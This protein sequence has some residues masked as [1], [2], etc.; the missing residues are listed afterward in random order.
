MQTGQQE[1]DIESIHNFFNFLNFFNETNMILS[2]LLR[3]D[4]TN[5]L[6]MAKAGLISCT[7]LVN[8]FN[9]DIR[10]R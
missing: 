10:P 5:S 6:V 2:I 7:S 8:E 4:D 1:L 9:I 3:T